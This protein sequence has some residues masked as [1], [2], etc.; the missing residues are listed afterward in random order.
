MADDKYIKYLNDPSYQAKHDRE[1]TTVGKLANAVKAGITIAAV[2]VGGYGVWKSGAM[3][4]LGEAT[5][6]KLGKYGDQARYVGAHV[7]ALGQ[8]LEGRSVLSYFNPGV[9]ARFKTHLTSNLK[10]LGS[11]AGDPGS[12]RMWSLIEKLLENRTTRDYARKVAM[13]EYRDRSIVG[14]IRNALPD[15]GE[16]FRKQVATYFNRGIK[17]DAFY[18]EYASED[19][20]KRRDFIKGIFDG[21]YIELDGIDKDKATDALWGAVDAWHDPKQYLK[22]RATKQEKKDFAAGVKEMLDSLNAQIGATQPKANSWFVQ[23]MAKMGRVP[24]T[25]GE[26]IKRGLIPDSVLGPVTVAGEET[27]SPIAVRKVF[28]S[29][30]KKDPSFANTIVDGGAYLNRAGDVTD[31]N[32]L[33]K[34]AHDSLDYLAENFQVPFVN[35]NPLRLAH[36]ISFQG[37]RE[38]PSFRVFNQKIGSA[39]ARQPFVTGGELDEALI[40][41]NG[42]VINTRGQTIADN[43]YLASGR[44]GLFPRIASAQEGLTRG[45]SP[46]EGLFGSIL[47]WLDVGRQENPSELSRLIGMGTKFNDPIWEG[48]IIKMAEEGH[49]LTRDQYQAMYNMVNQNAKALGQT[50][51]ESIQGLTNK[52][53]GNGVVDLLNMKTDQDVMVTVGKM[54][55]ARAQDGNVL[56]PSGTFEQLN[57]LWNKYTRNPKGFSKNIHAVGDQGLNVEVMPLTDLFS[58]DTRLVRDIDDVKRLIHQEVVYQ[59]SNKSPDDLDMA[60]RG[61]GIDQIDEVAHL[62]TAATV[63]DS[64]KKIVESSDPGIAG[65][66]LVSFSRMLA[67]PTAAA[68][69]QKDFYGSIRTLRKKYASVYSVGPGLPPPNYYPH[70]LIIN[71]ARNPITTFNEIMKGGGGFEDALKTL[72]EDTFGQLGI[73]FGFGFRAGRDNL[74]KTTTATIFSQYAFMR[75]NEALGKVGLGMSNQ[76]LGSTQDA[77]TNLLTKRWIAPAAAVGYLGYANYGTESIT[78]VNPKEKAAKTYAGMSV[79]VAKVRDVFGITGAY[80]RAKMYLPGLEHFTEDSVPGMMLKY[81]SFGLFGDDRTADELTAYYQHGE[82]PIRK[83]RWWGIG[84]NTPFYGGKTEYYAPNWYRRTLSDYKFTDV[85]YG[86]R[87]EFYNNWWLPTPTNPLA[88]LQHYILNPHH[89]ENKHKD[90]RPYPVSGGFSEIEE[91]PLVGP[92]VNRSLQTLGFKPPRRHPDLSRGH[93]QFIEGMNDLVKQ[94]YEDFVQTEKSGGSFYYTPAG[95]YTRVDDSGGGGYGEGIGDG[96]GATGTGFGGGSVGGTTMMM[97]SSRDGDMIPVYGMPGADLANRQLE[98]INRLTIQKYRTSLSSLRNP[99]FIESLSETVDPNSL[100]YRR[101]ETFY[102]MTEIG[103]IYGFMANS[104][105]GG[106]FRGD[107]RALQ[108]SSYMSSF[109]RSWWDREMGGFGFPMIPAGQEISEIYR[110]FMPNNKFRRKQYNPLKN[111]MPEWMPGQEYFLD[112]KHGDPY[113]KVPMGEARLPGT[114]YEALNQLHPDMLGQYGAFDRFKILADVAPYSTQYQFYKGLMS[115]MNRSGMLGQQQI[116]EIREIKKQVANVKKKQ[117]FSPYRFKYSDIDKHEVT[118]VRMLDN[119]TFLTKEFPNSPIRL[120]GIKVASET[121]NPEAH[122]MAMQMINK[123]ISP[124]AKVTIGVSSD[125]LQ[126]I[127][128]GT[129]MDVMPAVVYDGGVSLNAKLARTHVNPIFGEETLAQEDLDDYSPAATHARFYEDEISMGKKWEWFAHLDTPFHTKFLQVRSPLEVYKRR[130]L[131]G[132]SWQSWQNPIDDFIKPTIESFASHNPIVAGAMGGGLGVLFGATRH[133]RMVAGTVGAFTTASIA[134]LRVFREQLGHLFPGQ[135]KTWI[136]ERRRREREINEYFDIL[137]Y[138][139]YRGLYEKSKELAYDEEGIDLDKYFEGINKKAKKNKAQ[140]SSLESVKKWLK[141][142]ET[143]PTSYPEDIKLQLSNINDKLAAIAEDRRL[144]VVGPHTQQALLYKATYES[145]LYGADPDGDLM[146]IYRA[147]PKKD[148]DFF[149]HFMNA[150]P[151]EREEVLRL[152]PENQRRFYQA[153]WGLEVESQESLDNYFQNHDLPG[154]SWAGWRPDVSLEDVKIKFIQ[155]EALELQEFGYWEDDAQMVSN[156]PRLGGDI[157]K[158]SNVLGTVSSDISKV[159]RGAG[160]SD[161]LVTSAIG[162]STDEHMV[163]LKIEVEKDRRADIMNMIKTAAIPSFMT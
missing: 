65:G 5:L 116:D 81:G 139:K 122:G 32:W 91:L 141:I 132:K 9:Q 74:T 23:Q 35:I 161:V 52:V 66:E 152:V 109:Q 160:L 11:N 86:S 145:T 121:G 42:K 119:Q 27:G 138:M 120:A 85:M 46:R 73:D 111:T 41:A 114:G 64:Y 40:Y 135:D 45:R 87:R 53:F 136:P 28:E 127:N 101:G 17:K 55:S 133:G 10:D 150:S 30:I 88:P 72:A 112:F 51:V 12:G 78:G 14:S 13:A 98:A 76:S 149:P 43:T 90:D 159:L 118:V 22:S 126:R 84:S 115:Q 105:M 2:G 69:Q 157:W 92:L 156:T 57:M 93:E 68:T 146:Q 154:T 83:G 1:Q 75:L 37:M 130:E 70:E 31:L 110:R 38:A 158:P 96:A 71:K 123:V 77:F 106:E 97:P 125:P 8:A 20:A 36:W 163:S 15:A 3:H 102:S 155:N 107:T 33:Y 25:V 49:T 54:I 47:D 50:T 67:D 79:D 142:N 144:E 29:L 89:Y 21:G 153:K 62:R 124:G 7:G 151:E 16:N 80:K 56:S 61:V 113:S 147:L 34:G 95:R 143:D 148:R 129:I 140:K 24:L 82:D 60:L 117:D 44:F 94:Q 39:I 58:G 103:G 6:N 19:V 131:Y 134:S 63:R 26:A 4:E 18:E 137:K 100:S 128:E 48:K 99:D 108:S 59:L 162:P 104:I